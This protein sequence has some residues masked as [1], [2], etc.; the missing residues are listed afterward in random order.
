M[1][2]VNHAVFFTYLEQCRFALWRHLGGDKGFPG[3]GTIMVHAE[4]DY[5]APAFV[6]DQLEVR[7]KV[8]DIGRSSFTLLYAIVN[9]STGR[10]LADARTVNAA[11]DHESGTTIPVPEQTRVLLERM[12]G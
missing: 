7:V 1:G 10:R 6:H 9:V 11:F 3:S 8:A 12:R 5:R 4:C 2:H